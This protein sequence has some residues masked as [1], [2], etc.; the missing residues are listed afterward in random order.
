MSYKGFF[1]PANPQK[2]RGNPL[3][4]IYRSRWELKFMMYLDSHKD[5][6]SWGSEELIIP[7]VSPIDGRIHRYFPDF[8]VKKKNVDGKIETVVV[9]IKPLY[10]TKQPM[11]Q[12]KRTKKYINEVRTWGINTAKW[13][14]A[15]KFCNERQWRFIIMTEKE[16]GIKY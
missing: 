12:T 15:E 14:A 7:Y 5:V 11:P 13:K 3:N 9:E 4:I 16:L 1:K 6:L 2:Y 10:Q 8:I